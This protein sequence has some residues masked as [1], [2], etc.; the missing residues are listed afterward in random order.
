MG[1]QQKLNI[2]FIEE[3]TLIIIN[4]NWATIAMEKLVSQISELN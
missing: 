4:V 2:K 1:L 3:L